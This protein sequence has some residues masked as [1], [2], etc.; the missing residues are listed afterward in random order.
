MR[1]LRASSAGPTARAEL[2]AFAA[3]WPGALKELDSLPTDEIE[4]R[5]QL[6]A[7]GADEPWMAWSLRYHELMRAALALRRGE[8]A[9]LV[10]E[11]FGRAVERPP[12]GRLN[13]VVFA[14]L[15]RE[16]DVTAREIWDALFPRRGRAPRDYR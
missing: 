6:C 10:D 9:T 11:E 16:F 12:H 5:V 7:E 14:A 4:Q 15:A 1:A 8:R 13:V 2:R 3:E